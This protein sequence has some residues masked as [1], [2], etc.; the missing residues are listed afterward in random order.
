MRKNW[1]WAVLTGLAAAGITY[2]AASLLEKSRNKVVYKAE[3]VLAQTEENRNGGANEI[4]SVLGDRLKNRGFSFQVKYTKQ[5]YFVVS[6]EN[7]KDTLQPAK[8][9]TSRG[10]LQ[11]CETV[12]MKEVENAMVTFIGLQEKEKAAKASPAPAHPSTEEGSNEQIPTLSDSIDADE[13]KSQTK[14]HELI[15]FNYSSN[16]GPIGGV[17]TEDTAMLRTWLERTEIAGQLPLNA[18]FCYGQP[19]KTS[20]E[21]VILPLYAVKIKEETEAGTLDNS[22]ITD[23]RQ[24]YS[25]MNE[26]VVIFTFDSY[27]ATNWQRMTR[28]NIGKTIAILLDDI[29]VSAPMVQEELVG[30]S[31]QISAGFSPV[32]AQNL[33][34]LIS[35]RPLPARLE[36]VS[37]S[38]TPNWK[39]SSKPL[40]LSIGALVVL[41]PLAFF[42]FKTLKTT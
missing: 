40:L 26:P 23:A 39:T 27:G 41:T 17:L 16:T 2:L 15:N 35:T 11:F 19:L 12:S 1:L 37:S 22:S 21:E 14:N 31:S 30:G 6:L 32:D 13:S 33:A 4:M 20:G 9:L 3:Y 7:V 42:A 5:N 24:D 18:R 8:L 28:N 38:F 10:R 29:V 34:S 36:I 25:M